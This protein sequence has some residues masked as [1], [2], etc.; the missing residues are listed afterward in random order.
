MAGTVLVVGNALAT[1]RMK[2][3]GLRATTAA[4]NGRIRFD[5]YRHKTN[6]QDSGPTGSARRRGRR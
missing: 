3:V 1:V 6:A 2:Q 5:G 4:G